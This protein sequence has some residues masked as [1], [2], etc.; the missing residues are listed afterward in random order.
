MAQ[1]TPTDASLIAE[2]QAETEAL[3]QFKDLLQTEQKALV[4]GDVAQLTALS[5]TKLEQ[6]S[7]LNQLA[8]N[9]LQRAAECGLNAD[10]TSMEKWA[11]KNGPT[12]MAAW[13]D[14]LAMAE[15][16]RRI[17]ELNGTLIQTHL[18]HNHQALSTLLAAASQ[19]NLYGPD[20]QN[21]PNA[22]SRGIIGKA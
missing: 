22:S 9:R 10:R 21:T 5:Q 3:Q 1:A 13:R 15:E 20:G 18:Q 6:V 12:A 17:N 7:R 8:A 19:A 16:A 14:V 2:L 11:T 4:A